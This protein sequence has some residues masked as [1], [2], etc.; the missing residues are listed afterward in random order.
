MHLPIAPVWIY[1]SDGHIES[2]V[3]HA[4]PTHRAQNAFV[5]PQVQYVADRRSV[6]FHYFSLATCFSWMPLSFVTKDY[7]SDG[8]M[9]RTVPDCFKKIQKTMLLTCELVFQV[10]FCDWKTTNRCLSPPGNGPSGEHRAGAG[11]S[12]FFPRSCQSQIDN[13]AAILC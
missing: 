11:L 5:L 10:R 4:V 12:E 6:V 13:P 7:D 9:L 3:V 1:K 8:S 2:T